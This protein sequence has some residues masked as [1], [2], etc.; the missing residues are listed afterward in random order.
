MNKKIYKNGIKFECQGSSY[1]CV[2]RGNYGFVYLS[3]KDL[4]RLANYFNISNKKFKD[5]YCERT[6]GYLHLKEI[7]ENGNCQFLQGKKCSIYKSR[8]I[9]C[10]TWPFWK[11]NMNIIKWNKE[12]T[13][14]CPGIGKGNL[15]SKEKIDKNILEDQKNENEILNE[16]NSQ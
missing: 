7:N 10:R 1:C 16:I 14:F 3:N 13:K 5:K 6:D 2:S 15:Y 11:E 4:K 9:A 12:I 8:P